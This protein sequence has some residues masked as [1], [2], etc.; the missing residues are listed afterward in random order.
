MQS[1]VFGAPVYQVGNFCA[2]LMSDTLLTAGRHG[3]HPLNV[4][5]LTFYVW[6]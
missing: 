6:R 3:S 1:R 2:H 5:P 4:N